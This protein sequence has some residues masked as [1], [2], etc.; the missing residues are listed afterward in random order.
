MRAIFSILVCL[1]GLVSFVNCERTL[2]RVLSHN[3]DFL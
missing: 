2:P 1:I 3:A